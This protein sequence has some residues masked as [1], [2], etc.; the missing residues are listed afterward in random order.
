[1]DNPCR[2]YEILLPLRLND[3]T[4][5]SE[6]LLIDTLL[7]LERMFGAAS[8]ESQ[9]IRGQW[10]YQ[11]KSY[12]DNLVRLFVDVPDLPEHRQ[13]FI[14]FKERMKSRFQQLDIW[15]TSHPLGVL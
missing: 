7:E 6:Q 2:R 14:E 9:E 12:R 8:C 3:G 13:F 15:V 1:M 5:V 4:S 10:T 11:G